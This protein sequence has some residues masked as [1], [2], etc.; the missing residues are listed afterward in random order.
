VH[1]EYLGASEEEGVVTNHV[2]MLCKI[3]FWWGE[4]EVGHDMKVV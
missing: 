4:S 2:W 1:T 3:D